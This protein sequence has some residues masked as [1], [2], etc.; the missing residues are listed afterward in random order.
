MGEIEED[1]FKRDFVPEHLQ[2]EKTAE[3]AEKTL[4]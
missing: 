4:A 2:R 1:V 3:K